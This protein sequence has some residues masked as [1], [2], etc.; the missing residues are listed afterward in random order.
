MKTVRDFQDRAQGK[1][2]S[3]VQYS[4]ET[5][6]CSIDTGSEP[7]QQPALTGQLSRTRFLHYLSVHES[8][9]E[10]PTTEAT[11]IELGVEQ[12]HCHF[13]V[14]F[15]SDYIRKQTHQ[16]ATTEATRQQQQ[17]QL[18]LRYHI[19]PSKK[20]GNIEACEN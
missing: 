8:L 11:A 18:K 14:S 3:N 1:V 10:L 16:K 9:L 12:Q 19:E 6:S 15:P 5:A 13:T 2:L 7:T 4:T 20:T 17:Q